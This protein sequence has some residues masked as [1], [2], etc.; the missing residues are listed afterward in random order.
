[1][2]DKLFFSQDIIN[3]WT[4]DEKVKFENDVL[5]IHTH[6][7]VQDYNL[8]PAYR[9]LTIS[10]DGPDPNQLLGKVRLQTDLEAMGADLYLTSCII[11]ECAYDVEPGYVAVKS[12][13]EQDLDQ[14]LM[15]YL[16]KNLA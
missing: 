13:Q 2:T 9:F 6:R 14:L 11:G 4:D 5:T 15:D 12:E 7:G 8:T 16:A 3:A 10:G 1:M